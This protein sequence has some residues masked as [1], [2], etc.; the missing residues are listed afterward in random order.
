MEVRVEVQAQTEQRPAV[1]LPGCTRPIQALWRMP[2]PRFGQKVVHTQHKYAGPPKRH[3]QKRP[4]AL[5]LALPVR[6]TS[7]GMDARTQEDQ[8]LFLG[9]DHIG[10]AVNDLA[11]ATTTYRDI[12]GFSVQGGETLD[13]R[14]LE[15]NFIDTNTGAAG[16]T[17][18]ELIAA[19][20]QDS[21]VSAFL[22]KRG[23]GIHHICVRVQNIHGALATLKE[24]GAHLI[25]SGPKPGAHGRMVAWVHPKGAHGVLIELVEIPPSPTNPQTQGR[26]P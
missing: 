24:R 22:A 25:G 26:T 14:G 21:E 15:V 2:L 23:E 17:R 20:R 5:L 12:L 19:T 11:Q 16:H 13:D 7:K 6:G 9:I 10:V 18:I 8:G 3:Q 1:A 4:P